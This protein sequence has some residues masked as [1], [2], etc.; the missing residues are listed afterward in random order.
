MRELDGIAPH[1]PLVHADNLAN[2]FGRVVHKSH[3][4]LAGHSGSAQPIIDLDRRRSPQ[5]L[6]W[7]GGLT[8]LRDNRP[9]FLP[10]NLRCEA[11][12][13]NFSIGP[14]ILTFAVEKLRKALGFRAPS[15][16][17]SLGRLPGTIWLLLPPH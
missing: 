16:Q 15:R 10:A 3:G 14:I 12:N 13:W 7:S 6:D 4:S 11:F 9:A 5:G 1:R 2:K 17:E 8:R